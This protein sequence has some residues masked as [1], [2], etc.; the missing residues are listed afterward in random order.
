[1]TRAIYHQLLG[2]NRNVIAANQNNVNHSIF[3]A[4]RFGTIHIEIQFNFLI[5][6]DNT[7]RRD[8]LNKNIFINL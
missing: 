7:A 2:N 4:E 5:I 1:L 3:D 8:F 6:R